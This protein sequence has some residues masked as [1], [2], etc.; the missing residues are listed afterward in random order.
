L[1]FRFYKILFWIFVALV[2]AAP[3]F[4]G[5]NQ[6]AAW[7]GLAFVTAVVL[8]GW[9]TAY[10]L[11]SYRRPPA[12]VGL[13]APV[14]LFAVAPVWAFMQMSPLT[15][16]SWQNPV[17]RHAADVLG[18]Q[19]VQS[20]ISLD[21]AGTE[22]AIMRLLTYAGVF[23]LALQFGQDRS[24]RGRLINA[25]AIAGL[26]YAVYGL[27]LY[28]SGTEMVLWVNKF[29]Y[30]GDV[31]STFY[32][33]NSYATY[34]GLGLLC[35]VGLLLSA[36]F[37]NVGLTAE[38]PGH[39]LRRCIWRGIAAICVAAAL[40]LT[41]S[42]AGFVCTG[43]G[44][45]VLLIL[46]G[47]SGTLP[48]HYV[49]VSIGAVWA[50]AALIF[51]LLGGRTAEGLATIGV[52]QPSGGLEL[53]LEVYRRVLHALGEA[54]LLGTGYGTFAD[55]FRANQGAVVEGFWDHAH[56]TY[57]EN[58]MEL[59]IPATVCLLAAVG[60]VISACAKRLQRRDQ[61]VLYPCLGL[62]VT[63]QVGTHAFFDFSLEMP[64]IAV[65]YA[66]L[67]GTA[68]ARSWSTRGSAHL[69]SCGG[70]SRTEG[71]EHVGSR[72]PWTRIFARAGCGPPALA[73]AVGLVLLALAVPHSV[74][75]FMT[76]PGGPTAIA[77]RNGQARGL[78]AIDA[79]ISRQQTA[80]R[81]VDD[82]QF[83]ANIAMANL[84]RLDSRAFDPEVAQTVVNEATAALERSLRRKP[85]DPYIW[86]RLALLRRDPVEIGKALNLSLLAGPVEWNLVLPR[87]RLALRIWPR[88][89]TDL[90]LR[91][92]EQFVMATMRFGE[93]F[94]DL[95]LRLDR[96]QTVRDALDFDQDQRHRFEAMIANLR[97]S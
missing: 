65:T 92:R 9:G 91:F 2:S 63:V 36:P 80:A 64:G 30:I 84:N 69:G 59:G 83:W 13:W 52:V 96:V 19:E 4:F 88:L 18:A 38:Q 74:A 50:A 82:G 95:A 10:A 29:A 3:L 48:R 68:C 45:M 55:A 56:N 41:H 20:R 31:T 51:V 24:D 58:A 35:A 40:L 90:R 1:L 97:R 44:L 62:A 23:L 32:N 16:V 34:A 67:L 54:P 12:S 33:R 77:D 85:S 14:A 89:D 53:R 87:C 42:R 28:F 17:W 60:G 39:V 61:D 73:C 7:S 25:I 94:A 79:Y 46:L 15:P 71:S 57:L 21:P 66:A 47:T 70:R 37:E 76:L 11:G 26:M 75:A 27:S 43:L 86:T 72:P 5:G 78:D 8:I 6:P 93:R 22:T 81:W 49:I